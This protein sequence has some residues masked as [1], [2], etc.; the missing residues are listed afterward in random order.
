MPGLLAVTDFSTMLMVPMYLGDFDALERHLQ[1]PFAQP[2]AA[3]VPSTET[4]R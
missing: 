1:G 4:I 3:D 2:A